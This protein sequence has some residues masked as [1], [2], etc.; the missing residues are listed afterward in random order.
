[1]D[2][3]QGGHARRVQ[4]VERGV[5]VP[6]EEAREVGVFGL[7]DG[8][9]V[10]FSM[11]RVHE[12][13]VVQAFVFREEAMAEDLDLGLMRDGFQIR[14]EHTAFCV[15]SFAVAVG[16]RIRIKSSGYLELGFGRESSL[17]LDDYHVLFV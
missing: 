6:S 9:F 2:C 17:V 14:V 5:N 13:D 11:M 15:E 12:L 16:A 3:H 7:G 10:E 4:V 8:V 1:M